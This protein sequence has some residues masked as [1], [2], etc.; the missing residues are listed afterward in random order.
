[1]AKTAVLGAG[2]WGTALSLVLHSNGNEVTIWSA[3]EPEIRMLREQHEH[4][5]KLPGVKLP[6]DMIFTTDLAGAAEGKDYLILA[7]PSV[8]T[9]SV[10]GQL[11]S[12]V[13]SGQ[14]IVCVAKGIEEDTLLTDCTGGNSGGGSGSDVRAKS[15]RRSGS[16]ASH[17][18]GCRG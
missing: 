2:S 11:A 10:A 5:E 3:M 4:V 7:V 1:M 17:N 12:F 8:F 14:V 16:R 9:R 13:K 18:G 15:C 6:G